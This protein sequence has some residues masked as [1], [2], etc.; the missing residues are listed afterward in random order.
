VKLHERL[1]ADGTHY[2]WM[3]WCNACNGPHTFDKR[4]AFNGDKEKPT[5]RPSM[6]AHSI[7][8]WNKVERKIET[9]EVHCH[10][11]LTDGVWEYQNDSKHDL[12]GL[13]LPLPDFPQ[14]EAEMWL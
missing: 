3:A 7:P 11:Y 8:R 1:Y 4:W 12:K 6:L 13:T 9:R 14:E 2:A 10:S 5:F